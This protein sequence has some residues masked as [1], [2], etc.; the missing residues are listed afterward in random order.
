VFRI[1]RIRSVEPLTGTFQRPV[2][3]YGVEDYETRI[4]AWE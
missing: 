3:E 1:D 2:R 4:P